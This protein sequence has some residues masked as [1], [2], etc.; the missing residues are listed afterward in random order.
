[1]LIFCVA[2]HFPGH[3]SLH[4]A[5]EYSLPRSYQERIKMEEDYLR[6]EE[7]KARAETDENNVVESKEI[8][9]DKRKPP[10]L[11]LFFFFF[12]FFMIDI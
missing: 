5:N 1:M 7:M 4:N 10:R 2:V 8:I 12:F 9:L 3:F 11:Q 6:E